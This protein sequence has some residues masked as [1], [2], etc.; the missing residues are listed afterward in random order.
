MKRWLLAVLL[1]SAVSLGLPSVSGAQTPN[2]KLILE[3][4]CSQFLEGVQVYGVRVGVTGFP[5][6]T[7]FIAT[8]SFEDIN[9]DGSIGPGGASVG[10]AIY[11]TDANGEFIT[12]FGSQGVKTIDTL[13]VESPYLGGT[14]TKTVKVTCEPTPTSVEQ[15]KK[16]GYLDFNFTN[17]GQCVAFVQ[18]GPGPGK[19]NRNK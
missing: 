1:V 8:F 7:D 11:T 13:T 19:A 6:N 3:A 2:P 18:R 5:P 12:F 16:G 9:P 15:C 10:P 14:A 4:D 17:Q